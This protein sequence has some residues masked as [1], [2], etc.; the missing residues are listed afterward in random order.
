MYGMGYRG[1]AGQFNLGDNWGPNDLLSAVNKALSA[2]LN[3]STTNGVTTATGLVNYDLQAPAKNLYPVLTPFR[4]AM[5]RV[6]G[7]GDT[8]THWKSVNAIGSSGYGGSPWVYEGMRSAVM[9]VSAYDQFSGYTTFGNEN[10]LTYEAWSAAE[11][12]EDEKGRQAIRLLQQ[13][14]L[15]EEVAI[16][17]GNKSLALGTPSTP[18]AAG[19]N[20]G[21]TIPGATY[22]VNVVLLTAE[23]FR[24]WQLSGASL[25]TGIPTKQTLT[26]P[27]GEQYV[28][29]GGSSN[30]SSNSSDVVISGTGVI[31]ANV[32]TKVGALAYAW[33]VGT[34]GSQ[35][36]QAV[37]TTNQVTLTSLNTTTAQTLASIT[38]DDSFNDG[39]GGNNYV[40]AYNGLLY[41]AFISSGLSTPSANY[42]PGAYVNYLPTGAK[43]TA[44]GRGTINEIDAAMLSMWNNYQVSPTTI[45]VNAQQLNDMS[46]LSLT[47]TSGSQQMTVFVD[48]EKGYPQMMAG[49]VIG[50]Y[51]NPFT[52]DGGRKIPVKIHPFLPPGTIVLWG[53]DLPMQYQSNEVPN[54]AE[55]HFRRD[56]YEIDWP[57]RTRQFEIGVYCEATL[58][59][60]AP[61][62]L[63]VIS[64]ITPGT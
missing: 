56:Y 34:S 7:D 35:R 18:T 28:V 27:V 8:G 59:V 14:M 10:P 22:V 37:T 26:S 54:V 55:V 51:F 4:N 17:G 25:V 15:A 1:Q 36:L 9:T 46:A 23:G 53:E 11:G 62:A 48:P 39:T 50:W 21:G 12:F 40:S 32:A 52:A 63:G 42:L 20:T 2:P 49:G 19:A 31:T 3:K 41:A 30:K 29:R 43:L 16:Y 6:R 47:N 24:N 5:P 58:A 38:E 45:Y 60:Y 13:T 64:N 57:P 61:F 44:S 33:F